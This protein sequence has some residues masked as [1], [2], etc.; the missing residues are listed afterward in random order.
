MNEVLIF[1]GEERVAM[2]RQIEAFRLN[3][4]R[5]LIGA[6]AATARFATERFDYTGW[7]I[8]HRSR[9]EIIATGR[10]L[11]VDELEQVPDLCSFAPYVKRMD[12][13]IGFLNRLVVHPMHR[14]KGLG[15]R[16][17]SQRLELSERLGVREVWVE[18]QDN[19]VGSMQRLGFEEVGRS[20]DSTISGNWRILRKRN[21]QRIQRGVG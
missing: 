17:N 8:V 5:Q 11:V 14:R 3:V 6:D 15:R 21:E 4:W 1:K 18:V 10:L 13:P 19:R 7:H 16:V 20:H 9:G 2:L 12:F